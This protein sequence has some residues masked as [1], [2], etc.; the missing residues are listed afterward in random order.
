MEGY[1]MNKLIYLLFCMI[2]LANV[3]SYGMRRAAAIAVRAQTTLAKQVVPVA[4]PHS[5]HTVRDVPKDARYTPPFQAER[6]KFYASLKSKPWGA[7]SEKYIAFFQRENRKLMNQLCILVPHMTPLQWHIYKQQFAKNS[8]EPAQSFFIDQLEH[9]TN[10]ISLMILNKAKKL[11]QKVG[12]NP[13]SIKFL[14]DKDE[15]GFMEV[16]QKAVYICNDA[17]TL[18]ELKNNKKAF[19]GAILH[20]LQHILHDDTLILDYVEYINFIYR[21]NSN[22]EEFQKFAKKAAHLREKRADICAGLVSPQYAQALIKLFGKFND[23]ESQKHPAMSTRVDYLKQL[24]QEMLDA[25]KK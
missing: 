22:K 18:L 14:Y 1:K 16:G 23:M 8:F 10:E 15:K 9:S 21:N 4:T 13:D 24:H 2:T 11:T 19:D 20:E 12:I 6:I 17:H 7:V 25:I 5:F 3:P